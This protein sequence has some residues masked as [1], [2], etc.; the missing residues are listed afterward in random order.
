M[1]QMRDQ[2]VLP[3]PVVRPDWLAL[4]REEALEPDLP[5]IDP[6]HHFSCHADE[7][8]DAMALAAEI[9]GGHRIEQTIYI[10]CRAYYRPDGPMEMRPVGETE[11]VGDEVSDQRS[12][13]SIAAGIVAFADLMLG[14]PVKKVLEAQIAAGR[15]RVKGIRNSTVSHPDPSARGSA[16]NRPPHMLLDKQFREGFGCLAALGLTFDNWIYH[17]QIDELTDLA[18][19]FPGTTIVLDHIGGALGIGPYAGQRDAV[20]ADWRRSMTELSKCP[21][22]HVKLGGVGMRMFGHGFQEKPKPPTSEQVAAAF[23]PYAETCIE[24]FGTQRC[25]F[26]SNFPVDK[27][28]MSYTVLWNAFKRIAAGA[29]RDEKADLFSETARRV[30]R[31]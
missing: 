18:R 27:P 8:Y 7:T 25:M 9:A 12:D 1:S 13:T 2:D 31:L 17:T 19:A 3:S 20:F 5:I 21:N 30:Y 22:V 24:L 6:H 11:R 26:E 14:A 4:V 29:S 28:S 16:V 23:R 10:E 15:G